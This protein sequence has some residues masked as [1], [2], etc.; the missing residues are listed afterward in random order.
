MSKYVTRF[1]TGFDYMYRPES[2]FANLDAETLVVG[3]ILGEERRKDVRRRLA[4]GEADPLVREEWLTES[5][6]EPSTRLLLGGIHP[7]FMGGEYL[8]QFGQNEI[9]IARIVLA[10]VTQDVI[11]I[12]ARRSDKRIA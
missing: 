12:R 5:K 6:L 2:Y 4:S 7:A 11:S 3:S 9:E 8:P 1:P 10:S